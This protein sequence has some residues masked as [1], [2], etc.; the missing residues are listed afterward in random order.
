MASDPKLETVSL[1]SVIDEAETSA[2]KDLQH[3]NTVRSQRQMEH[4]DV[5]KL[6]SMKVTEPKQVTKASPGKLQ[7]KLESKVD[8]KKANISKAKIKPGTVATKAVD[9]DD[10]RISSIM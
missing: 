4:T 10:E 2:Q 6:R 3:K 9:Q 8:K 5:E 7:T 1:H